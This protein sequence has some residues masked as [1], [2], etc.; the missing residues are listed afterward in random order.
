MSDWTKGAEVRL[1][2]GRFMLASMKPKHI[3]TEYVSWWNDPVIQSPMNMPVRNLTKNNLI[4]KLMK[5]DNQNS[6]HLGVFRKG[7][8]DAPV[9]FVSIFVKPNFGNAEVNIVIG[10]KK[11]WGCGVP[12]EVLPAVFDFAFDSLKAEK[13]CTDVAGTNRASLAM[14]KRMGFVCEGVLRKHKPGIKGDDRVDIHQF[15]L[16]KEEWQLEKEKARQ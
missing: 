14:C 5:F 6:F 4:N 8:D 13:L 15:A 7:R 12:Q 10:D 3:T 9:G 16:L 1:E 2:T 11:F